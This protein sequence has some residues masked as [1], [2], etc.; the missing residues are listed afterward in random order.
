MKR[1][2]YPLFVR[3]GVRPCLDGKMIVG[4]SMKILVETMAL[5]L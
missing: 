1:R 2:K 5:L 3:N 4:E